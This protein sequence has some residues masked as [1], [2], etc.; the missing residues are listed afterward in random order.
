MGTPWG[1]PP[2]VIG[3]PD[4]HAP[5]DVPETPAFR[6]VLLY[7]TEHFWLEELSKDDWHVW[8]SDVSSLLFLLPRAFMKW[9][10]CARYWEYHHGWDVFRNSA[11]Q[12]KAGPGP[13]AAGGAVWAG[14]GGP[15]PGVW[16]PAQWGLLSPEGGMLTLC[17]ISCSD[18]LWSVGQREAGMT[19]CSVLRVCEGKAGLADFSRCLPGWW[20]SAVWCPGA[21][22]VRSYLHKILKEMYTRVENY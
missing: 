14:E 9:V 3:S 21:S 4:R 7:R 1:L 6:S 8:V 16:L 12:G 5:C 19:R 17:V 11:R 18:T 2:V 10:F 22:D 15:D 20:V 13:R